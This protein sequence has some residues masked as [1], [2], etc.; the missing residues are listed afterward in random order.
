M[1]A[2]INI[3][4]ITLPGI[5][6]ANSGTKLDGTTALS[7]L[8]AAAIPSIAPLPNL[9]G[10][11]AAFLAKPYD[12]KDATLAPKPGRIPTVEPTAVPLII[13]GILNFHSFQLIFWLIDLIFPYALLHIL[14]LSFF[15]LTHAVA[16]FF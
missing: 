13:A 5:P 6:R 2:P 7:A 11:L 14:K 15:V 1:N 9:E 10:S 12:K 4:A 8:S 3:A 16:Y